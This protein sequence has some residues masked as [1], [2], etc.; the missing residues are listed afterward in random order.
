MKELETFGLS[1]SEAP[2]LTVLELSLPSL[3]T[4]LL[5]FPSATTTTT[6]ATALRIHLHRFLNCMTSPLRYQLIKHSTVPFL[7]VRPV[8]GF[9]HLFE[10]LPRDTRRESVPNLPSKIF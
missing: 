5:P 7:R 6:F 3:L 10:R 9:C 4:V 8:Q 1:A 2:I